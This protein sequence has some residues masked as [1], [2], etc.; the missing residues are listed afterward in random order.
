MS[1]GLPCGAPS[2]TQR[3]MVAI[4]SSLSETVVLVLADA[5]GLV[6]MPRRHVALQHAL[7]ESERAHGRTSS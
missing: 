1:A 6:E 4:S 2:S 5:D 3:T 7:L